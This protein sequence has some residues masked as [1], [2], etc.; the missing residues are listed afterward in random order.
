M[1]ERDLFALSVSPQ[2]DKCGDSGGS[3]LPSGQRFP[4]EPSILQSQWFLR[5]FSAGH[6]ATQ[7]PLHW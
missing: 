7:Q 5:G 3:I 1:C 4:P 2:S 6:F